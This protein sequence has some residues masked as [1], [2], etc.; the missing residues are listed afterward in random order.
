MMERA[1][2][3][4]CSHTNFFLLLRSGACSSPASIDGVTKS[5]AWEGSVVETPFP[6]ARFFSDMALLQWPR[7]VPHA[8]QTPCAAA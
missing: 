8:A 5:S 4:G 6:A 7:P 3:L 1:L 2:M